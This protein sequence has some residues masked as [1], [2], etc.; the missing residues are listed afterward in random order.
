M[1]MFSF[2][3]KAAF[4]Y[5]PIRVLMMMINL[6]SLTATIC[7]IITCTRSKK[8]MN[9]ISPSS[10]PM[11]RKDMLKS[12]L[13]PKVTNFL[14]KLI[15]WIQI[16]II[17]TRF[18]RVIR[19]VMDLKKFLRIFCNLIHTS[20]GRPKNASATKCLIPCVTLTLSNHQ[21]PKSNSWWIKMEPVLT[22]LMENKCFNNQT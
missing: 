21:K 22:K 18:I 20:D 2:S 13:R 14:I 11:M 3:V 4:H 8:L 9:Q 10:L 16:T 17:W 1:N 6:Y 5:L 19:F 12:F 7:F 15:H